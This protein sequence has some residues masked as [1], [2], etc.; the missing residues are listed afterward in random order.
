M[1]RMCCGGKALVLLRLLSN[2]RERMTEIEDELK[3]LF[4][5]LMRSSLGNIY[6]DIC[7]LEEEFNDVEFCFSKK[8]ISVTTD[9]IRLEGIELGRF[10]I[11]LGWNLLDDPFPYFIEA[12]D[13]NPAASCSST[14]HPHIQNTRLCEGEG[15]VA[16]RAALD[17]G[18][19]LDFFIMIRQILETYNEDSPCVKLSDWHG[20]NCNDCGH[21]MDEDDQYRCERCDINICGMCS[22]S[23]PNCY[24]ANCSECNRK[25]VGCDDWF[26]PGCVELCE[27]CNDY[28]C[29][30]C[31]TDEICNTCLE[32]RNEEESQESD[33]ETNTPV[34]V[35]AICVGEVIVSS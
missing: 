34:E 15:Q 22:A 12:L 21:H 25:C 20:I 5:P 19:F 16:I 1:K 2:F 17:Q 4:K 9:D 3:A 27:T 18:R 24:E 13:P 30:E 35:H 23:C 14:T 26:C 10:Q 32:K 6:T 33:S 7:V 31:L 8:L 29:K 11:V 28:F